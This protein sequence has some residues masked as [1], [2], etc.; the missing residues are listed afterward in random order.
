MSDP[1]SNIEMRRLDPTLGYTG[2][3]DT[4]RYEDLDP[5]DLPERRLEA[6]DWECSVI[7]DMGNIVTCTTHEHGCVIRHFFAIEPDADP[8]IAM[9][10]VYSILTEEDAAPIDICPDA[11]MLVKADRVTVET[12]QERIV[13]TANDGALDMVLSI[14]RTLHAQSAQAKPTPPPVDAQTPPMAENDDLPPF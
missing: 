1:F 8:T 5:P 14:L 12:D 10:A 9:S 6:R 11:S 4:T 3:A 2:L 13:F 7:A